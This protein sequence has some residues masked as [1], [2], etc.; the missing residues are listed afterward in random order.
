MKT[1]SRKQFDGST[2]QLAARVQAFKDALAA[3]ALTVGVPAPR[4]EDWIETLAKSGEQF[5]VEPLPAEPAPVPE[6]TLEQRKARAMIDVNRAFD[7]AIEKLCAGYPWN[8]RLTWHI[9]EAEAKAWQL[10]PLAAT[11]YADALALGRAIDRVALLNKILAK[12][13][14]FRAKSAELVGLRHKWEDE[15]V[16]A[17]DEVT[18]GAMKD[19]ATGALT[20]EL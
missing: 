17:L 19:A 20:A 2:E 8:E 18:L 7:T 11:P 6:P 5:E 14:L 13:A 4:E 3:H 15:I 10:N 12:S 16:A 1:I 9:Q